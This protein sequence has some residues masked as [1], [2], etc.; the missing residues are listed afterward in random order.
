MKSYTCKPRQV[1]QQDGKGPKFPFG[2]EA[3]EYTEEAD[4]EIRN[5]LSMCSFEE[6]RK[7]NKSFLDLAQSS[8]CGMG[9]DHLLITVDKTAKEVA[10]VLSKVKFGFGQKYRWSARED[11]Y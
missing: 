11:K 4:T 7:N 8:E 10:E 1:L 3:L 2:N 9:T 6:D 5:L